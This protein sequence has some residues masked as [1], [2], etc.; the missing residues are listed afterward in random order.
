MDR[1][2]PARGLLACPVCGEA[3][4]PDGAAVGCRRG[5]SFD[6]ARQGYLNLLGGPQPANA[7][8]AEMVAARQRFLSAGLYEPIATEVARR[9]ARQPVVLEVGAG[10]GHYLA[11]VLDANPVARGVAVDVSVAA[12]RVAARAHPRASS[13]VA[14]VWQGLPLLSGRFGGVA[15]VFAPRNWAEF[16]RVLVEGG[17]LVVVVPNPDH[18]AGLRDR[19]DLLGIGEDKQERL[20][21][22]A[23]GA[24]EPLGT[25]RLRYSV[26][27]SADQVADLI[28]M[29]PNAFH[30]VPEVT[31]PAELDVSVTVFWFRRR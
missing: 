17:T 27:A 6:V 24:F 3:L 11:K 12:A 19:Y 29:G 22:D 14:D 30:G 16:A 20:L 8:T 28:A 5:H 13:V 10:T 26:S 21:R 25:K 9:L 4:R 31:E 23:A 7:D 1:L 15:C 18:L 2:A